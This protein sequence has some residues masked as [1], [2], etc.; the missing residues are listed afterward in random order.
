MV[1]LAVWYDQ[2]AGDDSRPGQ[3]EII[4]RT[5][6]ELDA[7]IDRVLAETVSHR[8]PAAIQVGINGRAGYPILEVG[9]GH[10]MGFIHYHADDA[11]GTKGDGNPD[12]YAEYVYMGSLSE[13][14]ADSEVPIADVRRGLHE[15]LTTGLRPSV[16]QD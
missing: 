6:D 15:F 7:L 1:E 14:P 4:V 3:S 11:G 10:V 13:V 2:D 9:L 8:C 12:D 16:I 5:D